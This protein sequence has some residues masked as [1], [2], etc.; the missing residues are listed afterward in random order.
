MKAEAGF[1]DVLLAINRR[2]NADE[3]KMEGAEVTPVFVCLL[4]DVIVFC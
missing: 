2:S 1:P 3:A 4:T